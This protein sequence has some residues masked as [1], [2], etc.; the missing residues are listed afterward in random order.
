MMYMRAHGN[1]VQRGYPAWQSAAV[2][3]FLAGWVALFI[4]DRS[5]GLLEMAREMRLRSFGMGALGLC[6]MTATGAVYGFI[7]PRAASDRAGCWLFGLCFGF[8]VW[9]VSPGALMP[10]VLGHPVAKGTQAMGLL[11]AC[12]AYGFMLGLLYPL[13]LRRLI[14]PLPTADNPAK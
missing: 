12:L 4:A 9:L 7:F 3:G 10:L 6:V 1:A 11:G 14:Q 13:V 8:A 2:A 5:G